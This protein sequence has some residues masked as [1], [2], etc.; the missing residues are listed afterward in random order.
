MI[1]LFSTHRL[2]CVYKLS[3]Q[4]EIINNLLN[5]SSYSTKIIMT[6]FEKEKKKLAL[7][8]AKLNFGQVYYLIKLLFIYFKLKTNNNNKKK[9]KPGTEL[10]PHF[11]KQDF[12]ITNLE[13]LGKSKNKMNFFIL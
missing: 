6:E 11:L 4:L 9:G 5:I 12:L 13:N 7:I 10:G 2:K 3:N 1:K 8:S